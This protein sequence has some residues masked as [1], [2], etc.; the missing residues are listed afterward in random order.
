M[1]LETNLQNRLLNL[2]PSYEQQLH[3]ATIFRALPELALNTAYV[4]GYN[5]ASIFYIEII[6]KLVTRIVE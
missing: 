5:T 3:Y 4:D 1:S 6:E 2:T